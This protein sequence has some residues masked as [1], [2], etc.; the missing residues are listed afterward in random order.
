MLLMLHF[1][2]VEIAP[3]VFDAAVVLW[4]GACCWRAR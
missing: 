4:V 2:W 3:W 1:F